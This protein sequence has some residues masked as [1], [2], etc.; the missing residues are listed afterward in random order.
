[1]VKLSKAFI[2]PVQVVEFLKKD[3]QVKQIHQKILH[4]R[5]IDR[6]VQEKEISVT[7]EEVQEEADRKSRR[8]P[9]LARNSDGYP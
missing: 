6:A 1:M 3:L 7:P 5:I 4:R 9:G 2:E 8:Y